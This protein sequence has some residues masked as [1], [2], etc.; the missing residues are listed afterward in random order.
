MNAGVSLKLSKC[1]FIQPSADY[2]GPVVHPG[3]LAVASKNIETIARAEHPRTRTELRSFLGMCNV[4]R[5]FVPHFANAAAPLT[6]L[7]KKGQP[8]DRP[9]FDTTQAV[10]FTLLK[11]ALNTPPLLCPPKDNQPY[12]LDV[13][14]S[15]Y[16]LGGTLQQLQDGRLAACGYYSR[17]MNSAERNYSAPEKNA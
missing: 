14:A 12:T 2:L 1:H 9:P 13:D 10:A 3:K 17:T 11:N 16:Q 15:D 4:Y 8:I 7:L 5:K 6:N